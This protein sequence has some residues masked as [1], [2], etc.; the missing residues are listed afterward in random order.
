MRRPESRRAEL[1]L[2]RSNSCYPDAMDRRAKL[3]IKCVVTAFLFW[4]VAD[5]VDLSRMSALLGK[6]AS[7]GARFAVIARPSPGEASQIDLIVAG[8]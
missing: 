2:N 7:D 1:L 3:L 4:L 6:R 8:L 5:A